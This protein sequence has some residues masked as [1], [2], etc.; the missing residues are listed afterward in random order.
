MSNNLVGIAILLFEY[1][2]VLSISW[3]TLH[4]LSDYLKMKFRIYKLGGLSPIYHSE[5]WIMSQ[6]SWIR[7]VDLV[8]IMWWNGNIK[9][10]I[11][12]VLTK[13]KL[14]KTHSHYDDTSSWML[15]LLILFL[16]K[17]S[18]HVHRSHKKRNFT[19]G[20][21]ILHSPRKV[22]EICINYVTLLI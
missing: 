2:V 4:I 10:K 17:L 16:F 14:E 1:S 21:P 11:V 12:V 8:C 6:Y 7:L 13:W 9:Y 3:N 20:Y 15:L 22:L 5:N 18:R 19:P